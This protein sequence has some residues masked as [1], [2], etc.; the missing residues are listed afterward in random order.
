MQILIFKTDLS[1]L[2][3]IRYVQP[4]FDYNFEIVDW[5]VDIEDIDNVLRI[6]TRGSLKE[7]DIIQL[8]HTSRV[9]CEN[10]PE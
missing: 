10:L 5:S 1:T 9:Y 7:K 6:V 3:D 4:I 8:M 2:D